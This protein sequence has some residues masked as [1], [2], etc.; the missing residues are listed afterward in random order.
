VTGPA[1]VRLIR[2]IAA[3][4][5]AEAVEALDR[6]LDL[7]RRIAEAVDEETWEIGGTEG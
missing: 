3:G 7:T 1:H 6:L 4:Q 5:A 2:A